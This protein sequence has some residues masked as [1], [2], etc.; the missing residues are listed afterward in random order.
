MNVFPEP[1]GGPADGA[2]TDNWGG[3]DIWAG[4]GIDA[5]WAVTDGGQ[6]AWRY[7]RSVQSPLVDIDAALK[8]GA[9]AVSIEACATALRGI[10]YCRMV[11]AG[12]RGI[13]SV[14]E[15]HLRLAADPSPVATAL[16]ELPW[17]G[18]VDEAQARAAAAVVARH[19]AELRRILPFELPEIRTAGTRGPTIRLTAEISRWRAERKLGP[20]DWNR[21]AL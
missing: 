20:V 3:T 13:T 8:D 1:P 9:W 11:G 2:G 12:F 7:A 4:D 16:R 21:A 6:M 15:L 17:S 5:Q 14:P 10:F 18:T 19:D